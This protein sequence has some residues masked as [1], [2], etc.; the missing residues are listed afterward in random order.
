MTPTTFHFS[1]IPFCLSPLHPA[2]MVLPQA[3]TPY[4]GQ[5]NFILKNEI[6]AL[7]IEALKEGN[8]QR[9][10]VG[11]R[12]GEREQIKKFLNFCPFFFLLFS[13][14]PSFTSY[15]LF[16]TSSFCAFFLFSS[17]E[18]TLCFPRENVIRFRSRYSS[19]SSFTG[20]TEGG[21]KMICICCVIDILCNLY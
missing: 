4:K 17:F 10:K 14:M 6:E 12:G 19:A 3:P 2:L 18:S 13:S 8:Q 1:G 16:N 5:E 9:N 11:C 15:P 7:K 20:A 21:S